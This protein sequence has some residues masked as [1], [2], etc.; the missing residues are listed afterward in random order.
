[1]TNLTIGNPRQWQG[2]F[3]AFQSARFKA[4]LLR[5][6]S[7][8]RGQSGILVDF[9][10]LLPR[11][12]PSRSYRGVQD[13]LVSQITGSVGRA[14]DFDAQFH[15]LGGH[16][17]ERWM[18]LYLL[19]IE[20]GSWPLIQVIKVGGQYFVEDGHHRVSVARSLGMAYIQAEV[21]EYSPRNLPLPTGSCPL[22]ICGTLVCQETKV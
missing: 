2:A 5:L 12:N 17:L 1:M 14:A 7:R 18:R 3:Q 13:I 16:L 20:T 21:W 8:L 22:E 6:I 11:L 9:N 10:S 19:W 15:P 4:G